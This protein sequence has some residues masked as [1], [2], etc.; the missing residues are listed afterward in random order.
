MDHAQVAWLA[1]AFAPAIKS[2]MAEQVLPLLARIDELE[3]AAEMHRAANVPEERLAEIAKDA[4]VGALKAVKDQIVD[5]PVVSLETRLAALEMRE[6]VKGVKGDPGADGRDG[7][8]GKDALAPTPE[9][10]D[11]SLAAYLSAK[12]LPAGKDGKDGINGKDGAPGL[13]GEPGRPGDAGAKAMDGRDGRDGPAGSAGRDGKD[14]APG[15]N[16]KDGT[17]GL[18]FDDLEIV[19]DGERT[20]TFRYTKGEKVKETA[21]VF[22]V[23]IDRGV[24]KDGNQYQK[25]DAVSFGGSAW[26]AQRD[27]DDK[28]ETSDAWRLAVKRGR[29]GASGKPHEPRKV[30]PVRA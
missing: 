5:S 15:I 7:V 3:K 22:P 25:G 30:G 23:P 9:Q 14:G 20:V 19:H 17:D 27:T 12:P 28:P 26:I 6:P 21:I 13:Q 29:D 1:E 24:F 8:D 2:Y 11:A 18:G 16:G 4:V 10:I